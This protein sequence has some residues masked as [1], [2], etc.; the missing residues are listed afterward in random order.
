VA[1]LNEFI[2]QAHF[3]H[4]AGPAEGVRPLEVDQVVAEWR[5]LLGRTE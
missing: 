3:S 5:E 1:A 4:V 2:R